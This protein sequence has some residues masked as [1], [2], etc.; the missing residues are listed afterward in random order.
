MQRA[1]KL[2]DHL[3]GKSAFSRTWRCVIPGCSETG[4]NRSWWFDHVAF[5]D[6]QMRFASMNVLTSYGYNE[7][8]QGY[9]RSDHLCIRRGCPFGTKSS[10]AMEEHLVVPHEGPHCSCPIT[11]CKIVCK[12]WAEVEQHLGECHT[13]TARD[14]VKNVLRDQ[15]FGYI[16]NAFTCPIPSCRQVVRHS[17]DEWCGTEVRKHCIEHEFAALLSAAEPLI[18]AWRFCAEDRYIWTNLFNNPF[19]FDFNPTKSSS[20]HIFAYLAFPEAEL[21]EAETNRDLDR[22][23]LEKG[24]NLP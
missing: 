21:M 23:C 3:R 5:H 4:G 13:K 24:I 8:Y 1:D 12:N 16:W 18:N 10:A 9:F 11:E 14:A 22:L 17:R 7:F 2:R 6:F 19:K 15:G 20:N